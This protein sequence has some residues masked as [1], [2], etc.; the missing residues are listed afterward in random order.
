MQ[1]QR[2]ASRAPVGR[3]R[4]QGR[5]GRRGRRNGRRG[6]A[7][8][9]AG[10]LE[11]RRA[12]GRQTGLAAWL[13]WRTGLAA[14]LAGRLGWLAWLAGLAGRLVCGGR[15]RSA[16]SHRPSSLLLRTAVS[17]GGHFERDGDGVE[18]VPGGEL[19]ARRRPTRRRARPLAQAQGW[20]L[21]PAR[22]APAL[23][24]LL[25]PMTCWAELVVRELVRV[26]VLAGV[27][28]EAEEGASAEPGPRQDR[29]CP[30]CLPPV[31]SYMP[32]ACSLLLRYICITNLAARAAEAGAQ[33]AELQQRVDYY[34]MLQRHAWLPTC[35]GACLP[36][37]WVQSAAS[38]GCLGKYGY[39]AKQP[40][41][42]ERVAPL[43]ALVE[44][45]GEV[46]SAPTPTRT[47]PHRAAPAPS[48]SRP[49]LQ[50]VCLP[51][52]CRGSWASVRVP[53]KA[54]QAGRHP[55]IIPR[56]ILGCAPEAASLDILPR[57]PVGHVV[58]VVCRR[59]FVCACAR[60]PKARGPM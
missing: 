17:A 19:G 6:A 40:G 3:Q 8:R 39:L 55:R 10:R 22:A 7:R 12:V 32:G 59:S 1:L 49:H 2:W 18:A 60:D 21:L 51:R 43:G 58:S 53:R 25:P 33:S 28:A 44:G 42:T 41:G 48:A 54:G 34:C 38:G 31:Y 50:R 37:S 11:G 13:A 46:P 57:S 35:S 47:V 29:P 36:E 16:K 14:C 45:G 56:A 4:R 26:L 52:P 27:N 20:T 9:R 24:H 15:R 5:R 30:V 23:A